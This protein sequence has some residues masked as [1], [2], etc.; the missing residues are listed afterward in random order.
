MAPKPEERHR[1]AMAVLLEAIDGLVEC[2]DPVDGEVDE[3]TRMMNRAMA[4]V[5]VANDL[6]AVD[7]AR[8]LAH[9]A[10][11]IEEGREDGDGCLS[12]LVG[13]AVRLQAMGRILDAADLGR[14]LARDLYGDDMDGED[15][16]TIP[17]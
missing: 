17:F 13:E 12:M 8:V 10:A 7:A 15:D 9:A 5:A 16:G 4:A 11:M 3:G 2:P 1:K 6:P 14:D